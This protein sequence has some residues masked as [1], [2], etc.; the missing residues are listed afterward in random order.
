M[1]ELLLL[2]LILYFQPPGFLQNNLPV[3][4]SQKIEENPGLAVGILY[5]LLPTLFNITK[6]IDDKFI[7][8]TFLWVFLIG[9]IGLLHYPREHEN[10]HFFY[11]VNTFVFAFAITL[12]AY[13]SR[14]S[15]PFISFLINVCCFILLILCYF[16]FENGLGIMEILFLLTTLNCWTLIGTNYIYPWKIVFLK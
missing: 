6:N 11:S 8:F 13:N 5:A 3:T 9:Y 4:L 15:L 12:C 16:L 14:K 7:Y 10:A 2:L 1:F